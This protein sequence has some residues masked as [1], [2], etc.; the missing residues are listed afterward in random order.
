MINFECLYEISFY[1]NKDS[2]LFSKHCKNEY[3]IWIFCMFLHVTYSY[4]FLHI[5]TYFSI[6]HKYLNLHDL[7][8]I[9]LWLIILFMEYFH[10]SKTVQIHQTSL[11]VQ[12]IE[13]SIENIPIKLKYY[14]LLKASR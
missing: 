9:F 10:I 11:I 14:L 1:Q 6:S 2:I 8:I 4:V 13:H 3:I 7:Q 12:F 5:S